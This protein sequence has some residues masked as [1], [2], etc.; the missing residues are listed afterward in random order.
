MKYQD[1]INYYGSEMKAAVGIGVSQA[2]VNNWK[3]KEA[4]PQLKQLAIQ[5]LTKNK[6]KAD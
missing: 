2:T 1:L 4:I 6:L 5:T 3:R